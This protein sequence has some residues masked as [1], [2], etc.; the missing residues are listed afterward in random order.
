M[1]AAP[2]TVL[3]VDEGQGWFGAQR[4]IAQMAPQFREAGYTLAL[5]GCEGTQ[6]QREW[7]DVVGGPSYE[8]PALNLSARSARGKISPAASVRA[9][10][11][12]AGRARRIHAVIKKSR[13]DVVVA[14]S[15]WTHFDVPVAARIARVPSVLYLHED[16]SP[17]L[18]A[19]AHRAVIRLSGHAI[20]VSPTVASG[21][22]A[23]RGM[24]VITNGVDCDAFTPGPPSPVVR[25]ALAASPERPV[26][27]AIGRL[28]PGKQMDHAIRAVSVLAPPFDTAQLAVVGVSMIDSEYAERLET[29]GR[30]LLGERV[31]FV[32]R[33]DDIV[34]VLRSADVHVVASAYEGFGLT[35]VEAQAVGCPV[36]AYASS[37]LSNTVTDNETGLLVPMNQWRDLSAGIARVLGDAQLRDRLIAA[38]K[39]SARRDFSLDRQARE[40]VAFIDRAV[41]SRGQRQD[42]GQR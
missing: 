25:A 41:P 29:L 30:D 27:V 40:V 39:V 37:G 19:R 7:P 36:V 21:I 38:G 20:A 6:L 26:I 4:A 9:A 24:E 16:V 17:G 15:F 2:R 3:I 23:V 5:L 35:A 34:D 22:G 33:R 31:R 12:L 1:N 28:H 32:G 42:R 8:M 14:N 13:A 18:P 10:A 11:S